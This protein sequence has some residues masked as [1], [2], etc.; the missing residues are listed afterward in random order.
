MCG[1]AG[2]ISFSGPPVTEEALTA[3]TQAV[4]HRG[5]DDGAIWLES[6][7]GLGFRRLAIRDLSLDGRQPML[8]PDGRFVCV[9]NGE[10]YNDGDLRRALER[11]HGAQFI[12]TG[13]AELIPIGFKFWGPSLF[14]RLNG[15][16]AIAVWDRIEKTLWLTRDGPGIK[17]L[18]AAPLPDGLLFG[19]EISAI[20]AHPRSPRDLNTKAIHA[21]LAQAYT[22]P[23]ETMI[24]GLTPIPAATIWRVTQDGIDDTCYWTPRIQPEIHSLS[25]AT[26]A[27]GDLLP[28]IV[29]SQLVSD[30]PVG[31]LQS[32]GID[33]SLLASCVAGKEAVTSFTARFKDPRFDEASLSAEAAHS[34]AIPQSTV[35]IDA[36]DKAIETFRTLVAHFD[37]H[38]ANAS[39][40]AFNLLSKHARSHCTVV[41]SG[42]GADELFGGYTTYRATRIAQRLEAYTP[43]KLA[44]WLGKL[45]RWAARKDEGRVSKLE[46]AGRLFSGLAARPLS[47][48][49]ETTH[50][51]WRRILFANL[52]DE[53][54]GDALKGCDLDPLEAYRNAIDTA[55]AESSEGRMMLGDFHHYLGGESLVKVD[56][57]SM[58]HGLE[59]RVPFLDKQ[60]IDLAYRISPE[61]TFQKG[62]MGKPVLRQALQQRLI[63]NG[64]TSPSTARQPKRGF[65]MPVA[66]MLRRELRPL[67]ETYF[68]ERADNLS[69]YLAPEGMRQ[70]WRDHLSYK[71]NHGYL[72]WTALVFA[73]WLET[74]N[75]SKQTPKAPLADWERLPSI[76]A[77]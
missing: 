58:A 73:L 15:M 66:S 61:V 40:F 17:P 30:V 19:S 46:A 20:M 59:V 12:S 42:D 35:T 18:Y 38:C 11:D 52:H 75:T 72:L 4:Q 37:G 62:Q 71:A 32:G 44:A 16:F 23:D 68:E 60:M 56:R 13:D 28:K 39:A 10:I 76:T 24:A 33:S 64:R 48:S 7:A 21:F 47:R 34:M 14:E 67:A 57:M 41:L 27:V 6:D 43:Q 8:S 49:I 65:T 3:M 45:G 1:F 51:E 29:N 53:V 5:P 70:V 54:L 25:E 77:P 36:S 2:I 55:Q 50:A 9:F 74:F 26:E 69:P 63:V 22:N 31:V